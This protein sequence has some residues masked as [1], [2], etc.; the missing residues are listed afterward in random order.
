MEEVEML[1]ISKGFNK[2]VKP[3]NLFIN[4]KCSIYINGYYRVDFNGSS[5]FSNSLSVYELLGFL[6]YY[7]LI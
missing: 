7:D 4:N 1:L 5:W 2:T 3:S 6:T